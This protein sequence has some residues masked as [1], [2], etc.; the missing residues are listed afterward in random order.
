MEIMANKNQTT[1][2]SYSFIA[3]IVAGLAF[4]STA[5]FLITKFLLVIGMF[6]GATSDTLNRGLLLSAGFTILAIAIY[7]ALEPEKTRQVITGRQARYGSNA[8][9]MTIAFL[10]ILIVG[11][12]LTFQ[13]PKRLDLTQDKSHT[14]APETLKALET[15]PAPV[16]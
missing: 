7:V 3:L 12:V 11:N 15:L 9:V 2:R 10:G 6:S 16:S 1:K 13:N 14:L 8:F 4:I 5:L